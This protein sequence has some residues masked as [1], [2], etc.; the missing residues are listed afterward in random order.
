MPIYI[1]EDCARG[2]FKADITLGVLQIW[3][4]KSPD[5][6]GYGP[7]CEFCDNSKTIYQV[8]VIGEK[9]DTETIV[10]EKM[11]QELHKAKN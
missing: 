3:F 11:K 9:M 10:T 2:N 8:Q 6:A 1:C 4:R 7:R 5:P